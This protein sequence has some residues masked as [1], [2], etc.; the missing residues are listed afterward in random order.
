MTQSIGAMLTTLERGILEIRSALGIG[1]GT[2]LNLSGGIRAP[3][4]TARRATRHR[5]VNVTTWI[6]NARARWVPL[7]VIEDTGLKT[8]MAIVARYGANAK[9]TRG[10]EMPRV[11]P[12]LLR[13]NQKR[14]ASKATKAIRGLA[15]KAMNGNAMTKRTT[16]AQPASA[17]T[18]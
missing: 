7:F 4:T 10:A 16:A 11:L 5:R 13:P 3:P 14:R 8:K 9:F 15:T 17:T 2:P 18:H 6:A 12:T 1:L